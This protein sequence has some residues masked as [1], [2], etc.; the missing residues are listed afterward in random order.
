MRRRGP[1]RI[2]FTLAIILA[3]SSAACLPD[4]LA[5][6]APP[7]FAARVDSL[8]RAEMARQELVGLSLAVMHRGRIVLERGW[9]FAN[10]EHRVP[11]TPATVYQSGS[12]GKQFT[13]GA[14]MLLVQEGR[15]GLDDPVTRFFPDAPDQWHTVTIRHLLTHT[16]GAGDYPDDFD[17]RRDYAEE[18][19][20]AIVLA[21]P[22]A[23]A[24]G[25]QWRYSNF[26]YVLLGTIIS[27]VTGKFYGDFLAERIFAP[28]GMTTA[29]I[30][31]EA[32]IV[33]HRAAGYRRENG[34]L[35]NQEWVAP[36]INTTADGSLYLTV[37]DMAR[38]DS[39]LYGTRLFSRESMALIRAPVEL[40]GGS[41][42]PYGFGWRVGTAGGHAVMAHSGSWQG[43]KSY[44]VRYPDDGLTV[45][46]FA[47]LAEADPS[48]IAHGV[49]SLWDAALVPLAEDE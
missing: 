14:I 18:E 29:R 33:P 24:P 42:H 47:N 6:Q 43:F 28:L 21:R 19:I 46:A 37:R 27:Q 8:V 11:A 41:T 5:A 16:S 22:L 9:G 48:V 40:T 17:F 30:I 1:G 3:G 25:S 45:V 4:G 49:A 20:R 36:T 2:A 39:A 31:N 10:L 26:G 34:V 15:V 32:D 7:R 35:L 23:F 13:A 38:W 12:V 44:I